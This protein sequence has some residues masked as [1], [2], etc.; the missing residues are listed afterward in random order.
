MATYLPVI[1]SEGT[2]RPRSLLVLPRYLKQMER[3]GV[4]TAYGLPGGKIQSAPGEVSMGPVNSVAFSGNE[5]HN[6]HVDGQLFQQYLWGL[7]REFSYWRGVQGRP[8]ARMVLIMDGPSVHRVDRWRYTRGGG[9]SEKVPASTQD[10]EF[11]S[12]RADLEE[13]GIHILYLEAD[14]TSFISLPD[15]LLFPGLKKTIR[16]AWRVRMPT[17]LQ[18]AVA[19]ELVRGPMGISTMKSFESMGFSHRGKSVPYPDLFPAVRELITEADYQTRIADVLRI[20]YREP[21]TRR[22]GAVV[23][24]PEWVEPV[25]DAGGERRPTPVGGLL[26]NEELAEQFKKLWGVGITK[27]KREED[28]DE[29]DSE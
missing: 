21:S 5:R 7:A 29:D 11:T 8:D 24:A 10:W 28:A 17:I 14:L 9:S 19:E 25:R 26:R 2:F 6:H 23:E 1:T 15:K 12:V 3:E 13:R 16:R 4:A 18:P 22:A 27:R 20:A